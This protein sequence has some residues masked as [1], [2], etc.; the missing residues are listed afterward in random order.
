MRNIILQ[1]A[2]AVTLSSCYTQQ[3]VLE[4]PGMMAP[5][6]NRSIS[7]VIG[8]WGPYQEIS[9]DGRGGK[10]YTWINTKQWPAYYLYG[11]YQPPTVISCSRSFYVNQNG[12]VYNYFYKGQCR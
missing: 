2:I 1:I 6:I 10:I 4:T 7:E 12:I 5:Y 11:V 3:R 9:E 8:S